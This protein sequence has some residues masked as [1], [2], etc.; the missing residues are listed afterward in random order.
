[1]IYRM[2]LRIDKSGRIIFLK[3]LRE[4]L[5]FVSGME[6]QAVEQPDGVL[7]RPTTQRPSMIRVD[8]LWIHQ[9]TARP[10]GNWERVL[11]D[12]REDRIQ[13]ILKP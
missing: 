12:V 10:G 3:R 11:D 4:R 5:G 7:M 6:L 1:M 13:T 2:K 9:G 8:G